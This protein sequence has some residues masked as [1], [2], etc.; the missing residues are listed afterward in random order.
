MALANLLA[1]IDDMAQI[2][3]DVSAMTKIAAKKTTGVLGDDL[4]LNAEQVAGVDAT[5]ELPIVWAVFKGSLIN[6]LILVPCAL[7]L[8]YFVPFLIMPLLMCGGL[9]L[10]YEGAHK[11][12]EK[13][14]FKNLEIE[15][16][17]NSAVE[18]DE[19]SKIK[20]AI[21]TDFILSAEI[22]V[23]AMS[24]TSNTSFSTQLLTLSLVAFIMTIGVY[25]LVGLIVKLDDIGL[26]L[27]KKQNKIAQR[28]GRFL[29]TFAPLLMKFLGIAGTIAM[30]SVG[31]GIILDESLHLFF[32]Q[33]TSLGI[34]KVE[35]LKW[36]FDHMK[37]LYSILIGI[38]AGNFVCALI[39]LKNKILIK[40]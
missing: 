15:K 37:F 20:G 28:M 14:F 3:D 13:I 36:V 25:G 33:I 16:E 19:K 26:F 8:S 11:V 27:L 30:F 23:I 24:I 6:K 38:L 12:N 10:C 31:G 32:N 35:I 21:T 2:L 34:H 9:F 39:F 4:A 1:L 29:L 17:Y 7:A 18:I 5:R 22:I 40:N